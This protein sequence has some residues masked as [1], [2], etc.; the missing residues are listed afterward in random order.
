MYFKSKGTKKQTK[1]PQQIK[2][3]LNGTV[4]IV[5]LL[6]FGIT[7]MELGRLL[8]KSSLNT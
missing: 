8:T 7:L 3:M 4:I 2:A 6:F 5:L 1:K